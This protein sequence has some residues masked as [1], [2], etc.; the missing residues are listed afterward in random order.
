MLLVKISVCGFDAVE[1]IQTNGS[2]MNAAPHSSSKCRAMDQTMARWRGVMRNAL[3]G[4]PV[5]D[6][7]SVSSST[8]ARNTTV[9]A[10]P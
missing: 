7:T 9:R 4:S 6:L 10:A 2:R 5:A 3:R 1:I 8:K